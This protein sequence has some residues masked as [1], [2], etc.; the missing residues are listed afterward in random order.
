MLHVIEREFLPAFAGEKRGEFLVKAF[1][2][3][4]VIS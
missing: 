1:I 3:E 2:A 4:I